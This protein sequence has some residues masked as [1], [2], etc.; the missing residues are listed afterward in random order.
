MSAQEK[1]YNSIEDIA[2]QIS[3]DMEILLSNKIEVAIVDNN[4]NIKYIDNN[5]KNKYEDLIKSFVSG[6]FNL[7]TIGEHSLPLS[8]VNIGFF[9]VSENSMV[10]LY[11]ESGP[12][13]QLLAF[14]G[15]MKKYAEYI[16]K[17]IHEEPKKSKTLEKTTYRVPI[18]IE[19]LE[20][21]KFSMI[22]AKV[23]H[24]I[25][26]KNTIEDICEKTKLPRLKVDE[27]IK[28][29]QKKG[30]I[31]LKRMIITEEGVKEFIKEPEKEKKKKEKETKKGKIVEKEI[32]KEPE[33][34]AA[35]PEISTPLAEEIST[36][37][38]QTP[39]KA[40]VKEE[41][42][43]I[44]NIEKLY[45]EID[46]LLAST[47]PISPT[48]LDYSYGK[49]YT[50]T[51]DVSIPT[52]PITPPPRISYEPSS[53]SIPEPI[54][55]SSE[56]EIKKV[57][58]VSKSI[59]DQISS[60]IP[61]EIPEEIPEPIEDKKSPPIPEELPSKPPEP[62]SIETPKVIQAEIPQEIPEEIPEIP[63]EP[64][65]E[66][67]QPPLPQ[68]IPEPF[69]TEISKSTEEKVSEISLSPHPV[70]TP[71]PVS[72]SED[73]FREKKDSIELKIENIEKVDSKIF[74]ELDEIMKETKPI[75]TTETKEKV[76]VEKGTSKASELLTESKEIKT[77][78]KTVQEKFTP[79]AEPII[80]E[81]E[82]NKEEKLTTPPII[83]STIKPLDET[84]SKL[85]DVLSKS[86]VQESEQKAPPEEVKKEEES[87]EDKSIDE[88]IK[89]KEIKMETA[90]E[91]T[92]EKPV[93][94]GAKAVCP[95]C[96]SIVFMLE[97]I[98]PE[99]K[100][101]LKKCPHCNTPITLFARICPE[102]GSIL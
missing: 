71:K 90:K 24:L 72:I 47:D 38:V 60:E 49:T 16:E 26:G 19:G 30:W 39:S 56:A 10:V 81:K 53:P 79:T 66:A 73:S 32:R 89:L 97:K 33:P 86:K 82:I 61:L 29:Y 35:L 31:K 69:K 59:K 5:L 13:G 67:K 27:I 34:K 84:L 14:K 102:C 68:E 3:K 50:S 85:T 15:K 43:K 48:P 80:E 65:P 23:I 1:N 22:E 7:L 12:V 54:P 63:S 55:V 78:T 17:Y 8:G 46:T 75:E 74:E 52:K 4:A 76:L 6:N 51:S 98:C 99:C 40:E 96:K 92:P 28:K 45:N 42:P 62:I 25:D 95:H 64:K 44:S 87:L 77:L 101:P 41:A 70:P 20:N 83:E 100:K 37:P 9:K 21:K 2:K 11:S 58:E 93:I 88:Y 36:T 57:P 91:S 94:I 18:K